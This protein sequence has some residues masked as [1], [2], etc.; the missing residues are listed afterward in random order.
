M[1][2]FGT[3][4]VEVRPSRSILSPATGFIRAY[5]FTLNPYRGCQYGCSYCYAAAF[6]PNEKMRQDWGNWAIVKENAAEL[7]EKE[8]K[9]WYK[10][11]DRPP[12]I[13][14]SSVTDPYQPLETQ[15]R[16]TRQLLE[17][18]LPFKPCLVIQTRSPMI[19]RDVDLLQRFRHLRINMS[20]PT[21]SDRVRRDFEPRSPSIAA[22]LQ[23]VAKLRQT[24]DPDKGYRP[25]LSITITPLLPILPEDCD[26]FVERLQVAALL[27]LPLFVLCPHFSFVSAIRSWVFSSPPL[28]FFFFVNFQQSYQQFKE[29]LYRQLHHLELREGQAGFGYE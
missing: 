28:F 22:R 8:L 20:I 14:M 15:Q 19:L 17:I 3:A 6:S 5:D 24:I 4:R 10:K 26:R 29:I 11:R 16:L 1:K 7:L 23:T 18:M 13:Y 2:Q 21:G 12:R 9:R 25:K 27:F